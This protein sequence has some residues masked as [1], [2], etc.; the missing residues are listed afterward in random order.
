MSVAVILADKG[1]EVVTAASSAT[2]NEVA[3]ILGER[4]I[5]AVVITDDEGGVAG[6]VSERDVVR[7]VGELGSKALDLPA[8]KVMTR[9]VV[10]C[11]EEDSI[12]VLA[13]K[14][15]AGRFRHLPVVEDGKLVGIVS[16][17]DVVKRRIELVEMEAAAMRE[18][19][20]TG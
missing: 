10:I 2:L 7:T 4:C 18:Y 17:G 20:A 9:D 5:G 16:I 8:R 12:E 14:M 6:I 3:A 11:H 19:I 1:R 13:A 15:T